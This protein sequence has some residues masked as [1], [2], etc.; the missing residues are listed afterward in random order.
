MIW[1]YSGKKT[2][3]QDQLH[4]NRWFAVSNIWKPSF[5]QIVMVLECKYSEGNVM[6]LHILEQGFRLN[7]NIYVKLL[8][9]ICSNLG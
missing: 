3:Y 9:I 4:N 7:S 6:T 5:P 1:F 8:G 2:F